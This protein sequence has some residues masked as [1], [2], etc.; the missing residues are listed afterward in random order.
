MCHKIYLLR[1][2]SHFER[3]EIRFIVNIGQFL[4]SWIRVRIAITDPDPDPEE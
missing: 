3:L 4:C 1:Y 2:K